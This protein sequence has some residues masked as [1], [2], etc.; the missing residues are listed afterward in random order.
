MNDYSNKWANYKRVN[1]SFD[2]QYIEDIDTLLNLLHEEQL[3]MIDR[4]VDLKE[5]EGFAEANQVI[6]YIKAL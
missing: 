2:P 6:N 1:M 4:A 3:G 5:A